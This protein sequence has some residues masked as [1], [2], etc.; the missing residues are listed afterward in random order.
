MYLYHL[1]KR[2]TIKKTSIP[3]MS[4]DKGIIKKHFSSLFFHD[5][6]LVN[7]KRTNKQEQIELEVRTRC[8]GESCTIPSFIHLVIHSAD[9]F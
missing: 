6:W 3:G 9:A 8:Q 7:G 5:Y 2:Q 4:D 1:C